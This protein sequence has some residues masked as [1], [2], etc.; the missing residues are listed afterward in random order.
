MIPSPAI[1]YIAIL[2]RNLEIDLD[3]TEKLYSSDLTGIV[4][5]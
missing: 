2:R 5:T 1:E 3:R 4:G